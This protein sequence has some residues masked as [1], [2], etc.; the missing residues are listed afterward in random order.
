M[1]R[2]QFLYASSAVVVAGA[3]GA[4]LVRMARP[5]ADLDALLGE[6]SALDP[7]TL[8]FRGKWSAFTVL[9]HLAQSIEYSMTGYPALK[10]AWFRHTVGPVA[11]AAFETAGAMRHNLAEPIPGA[12]GLAATGNVAEA[13]ERLLTALTTF[14][15]W[16]A[17]LQP[18]FAYGTLS[19]ED[20][21][22]AHLMH[23][24]NHLQEM[25]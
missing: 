21:A 6:L 8:R 4:G 22:A 16:Q 25:G 24:R 13:L 1:N 3:T 9:S 5:A 11:L 18:H 10:P 15:E 17:P 23:I 2:R 20:Y 14:R 19:R 12:P 7:A